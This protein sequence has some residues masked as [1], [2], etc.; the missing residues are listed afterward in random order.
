MQTPF[1]A[2]ATVG[3]IILAMQDDL[4]DL[5]LGFRFATLGTFGLGV[6]FLCLGLKRR[7]HLAS[8]RAGVQTVAGLDPAV[9][10][11]AWISVVPTAGLLAYVLLGPPLLA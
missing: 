11:I 6:G 4:S 9:V 1:L 10:T 8:R 7:W 2:V 5:H 3:T